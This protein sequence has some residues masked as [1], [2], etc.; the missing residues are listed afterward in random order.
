MAGAKRRGKR[1][2]VHAE[3]SPSAKRVSIKDF[4]FLLVFLRKY[5]LD[6]VLIESV[7]GNLVNADAYRDSLGGTNHTFLSPN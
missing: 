2:A 5:C 6:W 3:E 4:V 7:Q 1:P